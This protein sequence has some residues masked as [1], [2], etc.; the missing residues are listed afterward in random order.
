MYI[1]K[2]YLFVDGY[3]IINSWDELQKM[4]ESSIEGARQELIDIMIEY[5]SY[6]DINLIVVFDAYKVKGTTLRKEKYGRLEVIFTKENETA[7]T[8]IERRLDEIGRIKKVTVATSDGML[9][10][11]ILSRGGLRLSAREFYHLVKDTEIEIERK[12][13]KISQNSINYRG[14]LDTGTLDKLRKLI[15]D[16]GQKKKKDNNGQ[17]P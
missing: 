15:E 8:Y 2:E 13:K 6:R 17:A 12:R 14:T 10:Q 7:D 1:G 4:A 16:E 3:N 5:Q 11:M 9:Q